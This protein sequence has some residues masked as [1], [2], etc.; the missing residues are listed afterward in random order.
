MLGLDLGIAVLRTMTMDLME[1][2]MMTDLMM[3]MTY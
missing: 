3:T 1:M 2:M